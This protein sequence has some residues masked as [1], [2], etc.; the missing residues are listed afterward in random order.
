MDG[1]AKRVKS[2]NGT[3][4]TEKGGYQVINAVGHIMRLK[5]PEDFDESYKKWSLD[6]LPIF[7]ENWG[8]KPDPTKEALVSCMGEL[9]GKADLIINAGDIDDEGQLL[10]DEIIDYFRY[11][12]PVKRLRTN[13]LSVI[14]MKRA[15]ANLED[16]A[17]WYSRGVSAAA[18]RIADKT[19]GFTL[20]RFYSI[21]NNTTL[22]VGRVQTPTLGLLI[23]RDMIIENHIKQKYYELY[24]NLTVAGHATH[25]VS[26]KFIPVKGSRL[27]DENGKV[28]DKSELEKICSFFTHKSAPTTIT[29]KLDFEAPPLPF[30]LMKLGVYCSSKFG[31]DPTQVME[32]TQTLRDKYK[33]ITYNRSDCRYLSD[34]DF[35]YAPG[36]LASVK[37]NLPNLQIVSDCSTKPKCY[38]SSKISEHTA[39]IPTMERFD[40]SLLTKEQMNVYTAIC[41]FFAIQFMPPC[42]KNVTV[43]VADIGKGNILRSVASQVVDKGYKELLSQGQGAADEQEFLS[44]IPAGKYISNI[45]SGNIAECE[46]K[47]P[48]RYTKATL[49]EDM[50]RIVK[51][52]N[53][54]EVKRILIE[55]DKGKEGVSGSIGTAATCPSIIDTLITRGYATISNGKMIS[56]EKGREFY[57]ILPDSVRKPDMTARW[58]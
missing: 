57:D 16:N 10:V 11:K 54:P 25:E 50:S 5:D 13:D 12:G 46:T 8:V 7:F 15:L 58:W 52:V 44:T 4:Y 19:V 55:K 30:N 36:I 37:A 35:A 17:Q 21:L 51:Y 47:P 18:R 9:I 42:K 1:T 45:Q 23:S 29:Q 48:N 31:Y 56:T 41:V 28:T 34:D 3:P 20:T 53:D 40:T 24:M 22:S 38:D 33:A 39:I 26:A 49:Q 27:L 43:L 6:S 2:S 14:P 32:I